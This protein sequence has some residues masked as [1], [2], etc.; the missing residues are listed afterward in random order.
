MRTKENP[1]TSPASESR[2]ESATDHTVAIY[3]IVDDLLKAVGHRED[4]RR[5]LSDAEVITTALIAARYF[6]G[7]VEY[8]GKLMR[9]SGLMPR[10]L[11]KSLDRPRLSSLKKRSDGRP[12]SDDFIRPRAGSKPVRGF[13]ATAQE[14]N[15]LR[16][17]INSYIAQESNLYADNKVVN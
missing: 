7:N 1:A 15:P 4:A 5:A 9:Q 3:C 12:L 6:G 8:R 13:S 14:S 11:S 16:A 17:R 10:M 2:R